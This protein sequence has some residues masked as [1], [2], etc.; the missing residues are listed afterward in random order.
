VARCAYAG[1][2]RA[3]EKGKKKRLDQLADVCVEEGLKGNMPAIT[4]IGNRLDGRPIATVAGDQDRPHKMVIEI[5]DPT[6]PK[7]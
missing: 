3:A 4:E 7:K 1:V 5:L 2:N 6:R